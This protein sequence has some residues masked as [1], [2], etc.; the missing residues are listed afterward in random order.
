[1]AT[2]DNATDRTPNRTDDRSGFPPSRYD[3]VLA[4]IPSVFIVAVL[5]GHLLSVS[6]RVAV[7]GASLVAVLALV[8]AL[9][10][11]PPTS[12]RSR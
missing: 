10:I 1:M 4:V 3:L 5:L 11:N 2:S 6:A 8:D 7:A 9:F 12:G